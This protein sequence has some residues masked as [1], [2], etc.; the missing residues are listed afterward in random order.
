MAPRQEILDSE[1]DDS[2]FSSAPE[3]GDTS[4]ETL[5]AGVSRMLEPEESHDESHE[6][7]AGTHIAATGSTDPAFFQRVYDRHQAIGNTQDV[8]P[9]TAPPG[10]PASNWTTVSSAPTPGQRQPVMDPSSITPVTDPVA[11]GRR[12]RRAAADI[13][14]ANFIDLTEISSPRE[15]TASRGVGLSDVW[16][17]PPPPPST[18]SQRTTARTYGKKRKAALLSLEQGDDGLL[19]NSPTMMPSTLLPDTQD[20]YAFPEATPPTRRSQREAPHSSDQRSPQLPPHLPPPDSSPVMLVPTGLEGAAEYSPNRPTR[21]SARKKKRTSF[22]GDPEP[23]HDDPGDSS[24]PDTAVPSL[25]IT[26]SALTA[27]QRREYRV[28]SPTSSLAPTAAMVEG[29]ESSSVADQSF[30]FRNDKSGPGEMDTMF[31]SSG[32]TTIAYP[33]PSRV[34]SS[35]RL[36]DVAEEEVATEGVGESGYQSSPDVLTEM[37]TAASSRSKRSRAKPSSSVGIPSSKLD[38]PTSTRRMRQRRVTREA[39]DESFEADPLGSTQE[40][41][42]PQQ[43]KEAPQE[44]N[45]MGVHEDAHDETPI[46]NTEPADA[47]P[48]EPPEE[49]AKPA[50]K[51]KKGRKKKGSKAQQA[52]PPELDEPVPTKSEPVKDTQPPVKGKQGRQN[53]TKPKVKSTA[54]VPPSDESDAEAEAE[55]DIPDTA[56]QILSEGDTNR[57]PSPTTTARGDTSDAPGE[58]KENKA[59]PTKDVETPKDK[60]AEKAEKSTVKDVK[61]SAQKVRYRVGLSKRSHIAP[62]LKCLKK[63]T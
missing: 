45:I 52:P 47:E 62:L 18:T 32:A 38:P 59:P 2:D 56:P 44:G 36:A 11:P 22:F 40:N 46:R 43:Q 28:V 25:Y 54:E 8:I 33:T 12:A 50:A 17:M 16:D 35:R 57:P 1:D 48:I 53:K 24:M 37:G 31:K 29:A 27:S 6:I 34:T 4:V 5:D 63:Q 49:T 15:E 42:A 55:V 19:G 60:L 30:G 3:T 26:Q 9:D 21:S 39:E 61:P 20:P 23:G 10:P 7:I 13:S 41:T 51:G 14:P 58:S